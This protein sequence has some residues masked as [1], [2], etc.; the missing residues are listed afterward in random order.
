LLGPS[1]AAADL[2]ARTKFVSE[3]GA[4]LAIYAA[5]GHLLQEF[6]RDP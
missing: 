2:T 5:H 4:V 3:Q 1:P 6:L